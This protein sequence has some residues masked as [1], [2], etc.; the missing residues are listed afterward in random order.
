[1]TDDGCQDQVFPIFQEMADALKKF[2][3]CFVPPFLR[4][5]IVLFPTP[6]E[7]R[8]SPLNRIAPRAKFPAA[9]ASRSAGIC[10]SAVGNMPEAA[11]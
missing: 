9:K 8:F 2:Y 11:F 7:N 5:I 6:V 1:M 4:S 10:S 3:H